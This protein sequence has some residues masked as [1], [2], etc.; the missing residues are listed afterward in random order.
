M[1]NLASLAAS[2]ATFPTHQFPFQI[3]HSFFKLGFTTRTTFLRN[4][5]LCCQTRQ[6]RSNAFSTKQELIALQQQQQEDEEEQTASFSDD[7]AS[8]LSL[9]EK[10]DRN[11]GLLDDYE[12][13]ELGYDCGP[14]HRSGL[15]SI[16]YL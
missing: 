1:E 12:T 10:P 8:F 13:E 6:C 2:T 15:C 16:S 3:Q 5:H 9:S 4:P 7:D 14:N 11:L